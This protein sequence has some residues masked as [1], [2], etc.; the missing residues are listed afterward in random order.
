MTTRTVSRRTVVA[1]AGATALATLTLKEGVCAALVLEQQ[2]AMEPHMQSLALLDG[3]LSDGE[4]VEARNIIAPLQPRIL[5]P[6]LVWEW[7]RDL[8][9]KLSTQ[10]MRAIAITRW[11]K[12]FVLSGLARESALP[13]QQTRIAPSLFRTEIG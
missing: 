4:L 6:D 1:T 8:G 3:A 11:D 10:G 13:C 2:P 12:A 9:Q 7:R 5:Q